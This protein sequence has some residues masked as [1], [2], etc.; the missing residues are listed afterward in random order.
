ML[1]S[2][3]ENGLKQCLIKLEQYCKKWGLEVNVDKTKIM[4]LGNSFTKNDNFKLNDVPLENVKSIQYLGFEITYNGNLKAMLNDRIL[5]AKRVANMLLQALKTNKNVS[6]SLAMCIFDKQI[7][8]I[9]LYGCPI[10]GLPKSHNLIYVE[11]QPEQRNSRNVADEAFRRTL[12]HSVQFEY[13]RRVGKPNMNQSRKI[14]VKLKRYTDKEKILRSDCSSYKFT[15]FENTSYSDIAKMH[16]DFCKKA[17]NVSK[18]CS[19][20]AVYT[21][22]GVFPLEHQAQSLTIKYW[23]RLVNGTENVLLNECY[24]DSLNMNSDW[25][26]GLNSLLNING[27]GNVWFNPESVNKDSF[28]KIFKQSINDQFVQNLSGKLST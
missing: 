28:H 20:T 16:M 12:G 27:F 6:T 8:P 22:M 26:D 11:E 17:L 21:E 25:L 3:S 24:N 1:A 18:F 15:N 13:A 19:N 10:W 7:A 9:L 14:L 23:L 4:I 2:L 5:K